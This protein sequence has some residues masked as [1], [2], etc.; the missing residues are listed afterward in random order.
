MTWR[1][2]AFR[3]FRRNLVILQVRFYSGITCDE[4][5]SYSILLIQKIISV[6]RLF[7]YV[8][9]LFFMEMRSAW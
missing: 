9:R 6:R 3:K 5:I 2:T 7:L 8:C 1:S 4:R